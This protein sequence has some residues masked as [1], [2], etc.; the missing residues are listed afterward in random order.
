MRERFGLSRRRFLAAASAATMTGLSG[1]SG[2]LGSGSESDSE[3]PGIGEFRGSGAVVEDRPAPGGTSIEDLPDLEGELAIYLGGGEGGRYTTLIELL[4]QSYDGFSATWDTQPSSQLA[5]TIAQEH[6]SGTT[7]A[8]LFWSVDAGS[9]AYVADQGATIDLSSD[10]TSMVADDRFTTDQWA[11]VAG[12]SRAVPY[13]TDVYDE[14]EIPTSIDGLATEDRF[15]GSLGWAPT[16]GAFHGFV[17]AM[18]QLRGEDGTREW[19]NSMVDQDPARYDSEYATV[20]QGITNGEVGV[21]PTNHYYPMLVF[22]NQPD[23]PLDLAFTDNDAGALVNTAGASVLDGADDPELAELFVRHLLSA[24]AQ[25]FLATRGFAF[26]M[27]SG[28]EPVGPLPTIEELSPPDL[29]LQ[30]LSDVQPTIELLEDVGIL[31]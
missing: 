25:E 16:Y 26:P 2:I 27:V 15:Q 3:A 30:A 17:T 21:G 7:Q 1:C 8:D 11:G 10:T 9:L 18:R 20:A 5:N 23:A 24:E 19:L 4:N 22:A 31:S 14:S 28:V 13:N 29:D 12:R 6:E